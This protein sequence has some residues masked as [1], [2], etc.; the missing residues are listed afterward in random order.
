MIEVRSLD[1]LGNNLF[2]YAFGRILAER[3]NYALKAAPLPGFPGTFRPVD[4][5]DYRDCSPE[6]LLEEFSDKT[7]RQKLDLEAIISNPVKRKIVL[8]GYF[9]RYD[10]YRPYREVI[11]RQWLHVPEPIEPQHPEDLIIHVRRGDTARLGMALPFSYYE[12]ALKQARFRQL[13]ICTD[14]PKDPFIVKFKKFKPKAVF[15]SREPLHD[16]K[17]IMSFNKI[18]QSASSFSWWASFLSDAREIYAPV[19]LHGHWSGDYPDI[20][21]RVDEERYIYVPCHESYERT[22]RETLHQG[23]RRAAQKLEGLLHD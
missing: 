20:D 13:F 10:Y 22:W 6:V 1:R 9:Q 2:Q 16:F 19:P 3:M 5:H 15:S 23:F 4:G 11:R 14:S 18:V 17:R 8:E 21:L 7:Q 12:E